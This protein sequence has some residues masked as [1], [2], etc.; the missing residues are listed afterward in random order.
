MVFFSSMNEKHY[1]NEMYA[2]KEPHTLEPI[3][4]DTADMLTV[5][6]IMKS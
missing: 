5:K 3:N 6:F 1:D 4:N 2:E